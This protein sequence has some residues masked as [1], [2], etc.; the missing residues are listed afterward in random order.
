MSTLS[1]HEA[2]SVFNRAKEPI[3]I[4][5]LRRPSCHQQATATTPSTTPQQPD[6]PAVY[7]LPPDSDSITSAPLPNPRVDELKIREEGDEVQQ[8]IVSLSGSS[9]DNLPAAADIDKPENDLKIDSE[10]STV[11]NAEKQDEGNICLKASE[12]KDER[13]AADGEASEDGI[14]EGTQTEVRSTSNCIDININCINNI[15]R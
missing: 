2:V 4:T 6:T 3:V 13:G 1:H 5:V 8:S 10:D 12:V 15:I 14:T 11:E 9:K 7:T